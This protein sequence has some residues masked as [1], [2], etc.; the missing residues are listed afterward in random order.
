VNVFSVLKELG[1]L[2]LYKGAR[3]CF[4]RDVPFSAIFFPVFA[5]AK[6]STTD[7]QVIIISFESNECP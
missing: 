3:A 2:G 4:L 5:H 6:S 1:F 7:D